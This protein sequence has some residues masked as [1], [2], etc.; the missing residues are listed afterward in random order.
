MGVNS[1]LKSRKRI[2]VH[3]IQIQKYLK[4]IIA[5]HLDF[6]KIMIFMHVIKKEIIPIL[7]RFLLFYTPAFSLRGK[8]PWREAFRTHKQSE[9][10]FKLPFETDKYRFGDRV[11]SNIQSAVQYN[12][13]N[14]PS[15][16]KTSFVP[17]NHHLPQTGKKVYQM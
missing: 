15:I 11:G 10:G 9:S 7:A 6:C 16:V 8:C 2:S 12:T 3:N 17:Q 13:A 14:M 1:L 4:I 5:T